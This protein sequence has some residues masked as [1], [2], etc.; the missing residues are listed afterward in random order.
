MTVVSGFSVVA[1]VGAGGAAGDLMVESDTDGS[2]EIDRWEDET[3]ATR[4]EDSF[5]ILGLASTMLELM[6]TDGIATLGARV[7]AF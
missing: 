6:L 7:P 5:E 4:D 1:G 2:T 3:D